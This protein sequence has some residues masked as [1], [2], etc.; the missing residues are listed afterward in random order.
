MSARIVVVVLLDGTFKKY[1]VLPT[2]TLH[3]FFA[4]FGNNQE[5]PRFVNV[6]TQ[7]ILMGETFG[8]QIEDSDVFLQIPKL[9]LKS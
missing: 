9:T 4:T 7:N 6:R 5:T 8:N 2:T 3:D 1:R